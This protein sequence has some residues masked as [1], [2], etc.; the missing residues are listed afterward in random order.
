MQ[1]Y[2]MGSNL[3]GPVIFKATSTG[4]GDKKYEAKK[5]SFFINRKDKKESKVPVELNELVKIL[6]EKKPQ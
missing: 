5:R 1:G 3:S 6:K 2:R 4:K